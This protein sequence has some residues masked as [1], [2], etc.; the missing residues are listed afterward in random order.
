MSAAPAELDG[1]DVHPTDLTLF[2]QELLY[3]LAAGGRDYGLGI[4]ASLE[5]HYDEEINHGRL[6][7]NLDDLIDLGLVEMV[8]ANGRSNDYFLTNAGK[9]LLRRDAQRRYGIA[10][11][12]NVRG[13]E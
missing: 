12:V 5:E 6:Y 1:D 2:Q 3:V 9:R 11:T 4:K 10:D 7:P 8:P 13:G